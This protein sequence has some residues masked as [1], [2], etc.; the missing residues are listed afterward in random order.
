V[1]YIGIVRSL[2]LVAI[3]LCAVGL[4]ARP[5]RA[6][7]SGG[8][9]SCGGCHL[10]SESEGRADVSEKLIGGATAN[11]S[12][13]CL[14]CH[15]T[16]NGNTWTEN[17]LIPG[18]QYGAGSFVFLS[19]DNL[20]DGPGGSRPPSWI[21]GDA[22]GHNVIAPAR[23]ALPDPKYRTAP[24]GVYPATA[25]GCTSCHDPHGKRGHYRLLY[26][27]DSPASRSNGFVFRYQSKAP[28]AVGIDVRGRPE[29][30]SN[31]NAY[32][33]GISAW[34][35]NCH[36]RYHEEGSGASFKHPIDAV[37]LTKEVATY[38]A[39]RGTG[40][41][42]GTGFDSYLPLVPYQAADMTTTATGPTPATAT[43][44]CLSCHR[45]HASS[46]P[47]GGRWDFQ[48]RSWRDE[49]VASGS[50]P[51][52]NPYAGTAGS[53]QGPLCEKCHGAPG[54]AGPVPKVR[55]ESSKGK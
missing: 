24:G 5:A 17:P 54:T 39:Y 6:F 32:R 37:F 49:G 26:G 12:D 34:C 44:M 19:E 50:W 41:S 13:V 21:P 47:H 29:S 22:A 40:A 4:P 38:D 45:A 8:V 48:I 30:S 23:G 14:I 46:A 18:R 52:P 55:I 33:A 51:I 11:A 2:L 35:G 15:A 7:H 10:T 25:L 43:V 27:S 42:S 36:G 53:A 28:D 9:G 31:H 16:A 3:G 20:N 1:T